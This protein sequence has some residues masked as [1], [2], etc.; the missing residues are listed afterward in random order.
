MFANAYPQR[1]PI[2][3]EVLAANDGHILHFQESGGGSH[4]LESTL[5]PRQGTKK[6]GENVGVFA[7]RG[8]VGCYIQTLNVILP[9]R[10]NSGHNQELVLPG[11]GTPLSLVCGF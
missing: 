11:K 8:G 9:A 10:R 3:R 1:Q 5:G 4:S 7:S 6:G 2:Q